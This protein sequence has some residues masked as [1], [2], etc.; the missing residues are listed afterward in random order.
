MLLKWL[1]RR[2]ELTAVK[3]SRQDL[4]R[5]IATLR[6]QSESEI[7]TLVAVAA[8][9]R[10]RLREVG[11]L[12]DEVLQVTS[13]HEYEQAMVQRRIS[14]LVRRFQTDHEY[15]DAAGA[16]VWLHTLRSLS[17][18]E[19]R[20]LG[21]QMWQQLERGFMRT[22]EALAQMAAVTDREPPLG[23]LAACLFIPQDLSPDDLPGSAPA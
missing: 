11:H 10:M 3:S 19:L 14:R 8:V 17:R 22:P 21:R 18:P 7:A 5:F 20:C 12:P 6:G 16:I 2:A 9:I 23:T 1:K 15:I 13:M 4:E